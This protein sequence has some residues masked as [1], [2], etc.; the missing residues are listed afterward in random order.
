MAQRRLVYLF[1]SSIL[2]GLS[3]AAATLTSTGCADPAG[4]QKCLNDNAASLTAC[5]NKANGDQQI[6]LGCGCGQYIDNYNCYAS[7]CW[8]RVYECEYQ[9]YMTEYFNQCDIAK[10][11]VPYFPAPNNSPDSCSCNLGNVLVG[12]LSSFNQ[13]ATCSNNE[14]NLADA[15]QGVQAQA[16]CQCCS[17]SGAISSLYSF[18]PTTNPSLIG[19]AQVNT[20]QSQLG[21]SFST[22]SPSLTQFNC[23]ANL[24]FSAQA[25]GGTFLRPDNLP[26]TGTATLTNL[27]GKVTAPASGTVFTY[28][29]N[30]VNLIYTISAANAPGGGGGSIN[31]LMLLN[32]LFLFII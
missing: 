32:K 31:A 21:E 4:M 8:N 9:E 24:G 17:L 12:M 13:L 18:C 10:F 27:P 11:P 5:I 14:L 19:L 28:T 15:S 26:V 6:I 23:A 7:F 3:N 30:A 1:L 20:F 29:N 16:A 25:V 2:F 22:C